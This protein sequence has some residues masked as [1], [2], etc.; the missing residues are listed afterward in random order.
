MK[1]TSNTSEKKVMKFSELPQELGMHF[2]M[3]ILY[4]IAG[5]IGVIFVSYITSSLHIAIVFSAIFL[6]Y[7]LYQCITY[8]SVITGK[9]KCYYGYYEKLDVKNINS[10]KFFSYHGTSNLILKNKENPELKMIVPTSS[11]FDAVEGNLIVVYI[12]ELDVIQKNENTYYFLS[13]LL[14][15]VIKS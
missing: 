10:G 7:V 14:V 5:L 15:K 11:N 6:I 13:P 9:Y 3:R 12:K 2:F 4:S 8:L 1:T